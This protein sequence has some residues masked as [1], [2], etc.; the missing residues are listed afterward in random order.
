MSGIDWSRWAPTLL[1]VVGWV[2][3]A[4]IAYSVLGEVRRDVAVIEAT[5]KAHIASE[6]H[7]LTIRRLDKMETEAQYTDAAVKSLDEDIEDLR[8]VMRRVDRRTE[9]LC[10]DS[11]RC[12]KGK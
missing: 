6:G 5:V 3:G 11:P 7:V 8:R 12:R 9:A 4:G 2:F 1:V 10:A